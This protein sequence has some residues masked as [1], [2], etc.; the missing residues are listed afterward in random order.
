MPGFGFYRPS[1]QALQAPSE[2]AHALASSITAYTGDP[3]VRTIISSNYVV[4]PLTQ[5]EITAAYASGGNTYGILGY[6]PNA[7]ITDSSGIATSQPA[8]S[9]VLGNV[10]VR[11]NLPTIDFAQSDAVTGRSMASVPIFSTDMLISGYL[12]ETTTVT[13]NL[14]GTPVGILLSTVNSVPYFYWSSAATT[15]VG[16]IKA[17]SIDDPFFNKTV[18][19][20]V[21]DTSNASRCQIGVEM[22]AAYCQAD[23]QYTYAG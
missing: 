7:W 8:P 21:Q 9:G 15:K 11:F 17:V 3:L 18:S 6:N 13:Q 16:I 10:Q 19:A 5:T 22:L 23:S 20:N 1:G 2:Q 14:K 12:W 4:R